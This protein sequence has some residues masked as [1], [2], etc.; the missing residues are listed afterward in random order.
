MRRYPDIKS[1]LTCKNNCRFGFYEIY[2]NG[3]AFRFKYAEDVA[4][5][6]ASNL[7]EMEK[8]V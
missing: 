2:C 7:L 4:G 6:V 8:S 5:F 1:A 3:G